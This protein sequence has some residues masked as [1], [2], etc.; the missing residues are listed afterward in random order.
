[1]KRGLLIF[2]C[3]CT[4]L[5]PEK[6][7]PPAPTKLEQLETKYELY[8]ELAK[9]KE[10]ENG[11]II[12][13]HCDSLLW[14][15]L[16]AF[17]GGTVEIDSFRR[18]NK[19][20]RRPTKDCYPDNSAS[21]ISRDQ[22][23]GLL[24]AILVNDRLDLAYGV[25]EYAEKNRFIMGEGDLA[26][27]HMTQNML[28]LY[29]RLVKFLGGY[30]KYSLYPVYLPPG[31]DNY[32]AHLQ[33]LHIILLDIMENRLDSNKIARVKEHYKRNPDN[34]L[35][36]IVYNKYVGGA[37]T[38]V[39]ETLLDEKLF[40]ARRLPTP[41]DRC[42][43]YLFQYSKNKTAHT[44]TGTQWESCNSRED[45]TGVDFLFAAKLYLDEVR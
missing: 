35:F 17:S 14:S 15:S 13:E 44:G 10:D 40:P 23:T 29:G 11:A 43:F 41:Q 42:G 5:M 2:V 39:L 7:T 9:E 26:R 28:G 24:F 37:P 45:F 4:Y 22:L 6:V 27:T 30:S 36:A 16:Y 1:M 25:L 34:A 31:T 3:S 33:I 18:E 19:W 21:T 12:T 32:H 20:F 38:A 8:L